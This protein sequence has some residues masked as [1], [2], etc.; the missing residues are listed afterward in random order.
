MVPPDICT[1][2]ALKKCVFCNADQPDCLDCVKSRKVKVF[3]HKVEICLMSAEYWKCDNCQRTVY[4]DGRDDEL[5]FHSPVMAVHSSIVW[6]CLKWYVN[7]TQPF[8][9]KFVSIMK[10][11]MKRA[12]NYNP[13]CRCFSES[14]FSKIWFSM[15]S[16]PFDLRWPCLLCAVRDA[17]V[18]S[19]LSGAALSE[20]KP[21]ITLSSY[22]TKFVIRYDQLKACFAESFCFPYEHCPCTL[23][24]ATC[25]SLLEHAKTCRAHE[26]LNTVIFRCDIQFLR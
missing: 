2:R 16:R 21:T 23:C 9:S 11:T 18:P 1:L 20:W 14:V 7:G 26:K 17:G 15:L 10:D 3:T 25:A 8:I 19:D 6:L 5:W 4:C 12:M 13:G 22:D 24:P